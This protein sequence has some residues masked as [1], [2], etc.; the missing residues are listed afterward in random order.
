M[1]DLLTELIKRFEGFSAKPYLCPAGVWTIG[2][3]VTGP[4]VTKNHPPVT[5]A[6][7]NDMLAAILPRYVAQTVKLAPNLT[8][9]P[10]TR[11]AAVSSFIFNLGPTRFRSSTFRKKLLA[12]DW[13]AA[14]RECRRWVYGGGVKL[15]GLVK[16]REAEARLILAG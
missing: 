15:P 5:R 12:E 6:E 7:A 13:E 16:R 1:L 9:G 11:L 8:Q 4:G 10:E 3:G 2:Y 14:A